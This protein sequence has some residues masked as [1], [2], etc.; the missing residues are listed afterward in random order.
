MRKLIIKLLLLIVIFCT[1]ESQAKFHVELDYRYSLGIR[2]RKI[3]S[4]LYLDQYNIFSHMVHFA[5][6][7]NFTPRISAGIGVG[8][9][10]DKH[11]GAF[12]LYATFR[13]RPIK[14]HLNAYVF[15][16]LGYAPAS[17]STKEISH[18]W[19]W[20]AGV[21]Y[22]LMFR[23]HFGL[24]FQLCY[25]MQQY[26][27]VGITLRNIYTDQLEHVKSNNLCHSLGFGIGL[28]F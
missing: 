12:P 11:R 16:D 22:T 5:A 17:R 13:Y 6:L 2:E 10:G 27:G 18:G 25:N 15:T 4:D 24:N 3:G 7:Y 21:G 23:R 1:T 19:M 14:Q 8:I 9:V 26:A 20:N 28:V